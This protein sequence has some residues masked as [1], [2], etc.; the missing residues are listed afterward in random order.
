MVR[1]GTIGI[2]SGVLALIILAGM[3]LLGLWLFGVIGK[4]FLP[5]NG[6]GV[7]VSRCPCWC[8]DGKCHD[9]WPD[10]KCHPC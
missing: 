1:K 2:V 9:R 5:V 8:D 7:G 10:G 3:V 6:N 4:D